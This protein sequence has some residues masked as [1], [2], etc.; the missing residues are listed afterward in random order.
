LSRLSLF[1]FLALAAG[2]VFLRAQDRAGG[3]PAAQVRLTVIKAKQLP[4]ELKKLRGKVVVLDVWAW[5][6]PPCKKEFPHLVELHKKY[7]RD[8]V[9]CVSVTV[10][11]VADHPRA[12]KFLQS[13]SAAFANYLMDEA[14]SVW[15]EH[16]DI[17]GPPAV[18]VYGRDGKLAARFDHNDP[19]KQY[20][21]A[22]VEGLVRRLL[23][24]A[25]K[26]S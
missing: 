11:P 24:D 19:C 23:R 18:F 22:D 12:L 6:C 21:Y 10:D 15:Q 8:S 13:Q 14:N 9:A 16:F 4:E 5:F 1:A 2:A 17:N 20:T 7:G 26:G 25:K 3:T